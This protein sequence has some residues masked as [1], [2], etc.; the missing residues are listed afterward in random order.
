MNARDSRHLIFLF[1]LRRIE[2][3]PVTFRFRLF[4]ETWQLEMCW[5]AR[6][7]S[8][9]WQTLE[10]REM[11]S[12]KIFTKGRQRQEKGWRNESLRLVPS[13][14]F[15]WTVQATSV[16]DKVK[17]IQ[18]QITV[19]FDYFQSPLCSDERIN[20]RN[21]SFTT[22]LRCLISILCC[23]VYLMIKVAE[24]NFQVLMLNSPLLLNY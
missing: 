13:N 16:D 14:L 11:F 19:C 12:R 10:W 8:V 15:L 2:I 7:K 17:K 1:C 3:S 23:P 5:S 20:P 4:T 22:S 18:P 6:E 21:V 9:M 24:H